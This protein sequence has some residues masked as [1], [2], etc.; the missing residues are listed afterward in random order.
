MKQR[1]SER[2]NVQ[3]GIFIGDD[4]AS[5]ISK[6]RDAFS[7]PVV[8]FSDS[9]HTGKALMNQLYK[10][11][12]EHKELTTEAINYLKLCFSYAIA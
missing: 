8:K 10:L 6:V 5:S 3:V 2:S 11:R 9:N 7:H 4:D 12:P 1:R